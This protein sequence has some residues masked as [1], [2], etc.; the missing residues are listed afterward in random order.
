ML[1]KE[2]IHYIDK[3]IIVRRLKYGNIQIKN[4]RGLENKL[5]KRI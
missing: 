2:T 3:N 4:W 5:H 1:N